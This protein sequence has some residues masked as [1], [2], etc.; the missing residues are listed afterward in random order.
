MPF[1]KTAIKWRRRGS[2]KETERGRDSGFASKSTVIILFLILGSV[3][4][5]DGLPSGGAGGGWVVE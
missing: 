2:K 3:P 1:A 4:G 5:S